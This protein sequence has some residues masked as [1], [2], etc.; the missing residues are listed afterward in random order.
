[1]WTSP[2]II[3]PN[4]NLFLKLTLVAPSQP[5]TYTGRWYL[6]DPNFNQFGV[7]PTFSDPLMLKSISRKSG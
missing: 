6:K 5:G 3:P 4:N 2:Q 1:M 7:G